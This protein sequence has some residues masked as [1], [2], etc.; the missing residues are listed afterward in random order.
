MDDANVPSLLS[1]PYLGFLDRDNEA[2]V[3]TRQVIPMLHRVRLEANY[4]DPGVA[5]FKEP[6]LCLRKW[7]QRDGVSYPPM[8][9]Y[10]SF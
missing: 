3:K 7:F 6:L 9:T 2:Y 5:V 1:L 10:R 8:K 4:A